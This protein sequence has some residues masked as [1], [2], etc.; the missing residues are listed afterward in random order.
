MKGRGLI[1]LMGPSGSGK[2]TLLA[3]L[4]GLLPL[5][6]RVRIARRSITRPADGEASEA[7]TPDVFQRRVARGEFALH[8]QSHGLF[9]GIDMVIEHW[10]AQGDTVIVNGSRAHLPQAHARYPGLIAVSITVKP[11]ALAARLRRRARE[12]EADIQ[13]RLTRAQTVFPV[14]ASCKHIQIANDDAPIVAA[15]ALAELVRSASPGCAPR[16]DR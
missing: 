13:A 8:W 2:D 11:Q 4:P 14:P 10:L 3:L 5:D 12:S 6:A 16:S 1:Y 9:Y 7:V 15:R